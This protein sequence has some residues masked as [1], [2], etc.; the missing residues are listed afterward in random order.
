ME[1]VLSGGVGAILAGSF[2]AAVEPAAAP[3]LTFF[4]M[5]K[6][7]EWV[8]IPIALLSF[9]IVGI[10][11][12][13]FFFL[14]RRTIASAAFI[15]LA[16]RLLNDKNVEAMLELCS[17][18]DQYCAVVLHKVILFAR[19]NPRTD[20]ANL[21]R[22]AESEGSALSARLNVPTQLLMDLGVLSP[23]VGLLGT[24][25]GILKSFGTL[26]S[27][28]TPMK[29]MLLA[30]GVSQ[31]LIA[32]AMGLLIGLLA[33]AFYAFFRARVQV[34]LGYFDQSLAPLLAK[35]LDRLAGD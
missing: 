16:E 14:R 7:A 26:A 25:Y 24:V 9:A 27:D 17:K 30:G 23:M 34:L 18:S 13:N 35:T 6:S 28:A 5:V 11:I 10:I 19:D 33:M 21:L 8:L 3:Q 2:L 32:T 20:V 1:P 31:A 29:T 15:S 4:E 12:Y 22:I